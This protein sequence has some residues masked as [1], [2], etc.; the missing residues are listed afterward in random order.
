MNDKMLSQISKDKHFIKNI[1]VKN[2]KKHQLF[3][4]NGCWCNCTTKA[5]ESDHT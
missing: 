3:I 2:K 4:F 5:K 1:I